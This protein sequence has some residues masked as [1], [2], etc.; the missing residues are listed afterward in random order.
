MLTVVP[1]GMFCIYKRIAKISGIF[2]MIFCFNLTLIGN[3]GLQ[4]IMLLAI[5]FVN[6]DDEFLD[7]LF[8]LGEEK[9]VHSKDGRIITL[10]N[11]EELSVIIGIDIFIIIIF[12]IFSLFVFF[13]LFRIN[14]GHFDLTPGGE[15]NPYR[16]L[17]IS[18][19]KTIMILFIIYIVIMSIIDYYN[20]HLKKEEDFK[21]VKNFSDLRNSCKMGIVLKILIFSV[22]GII[23]LCHSADTFY[24][25]LNIPMVTKK[26]GSFLYSSTHQLFNFLHDYTISSGYNI[27]KGLLE[28]E[29][30]K[31]DEKK[32]EKKN[33]NNIINEINKTN[34]TNNINDTKNINKTNETLSDNINLNNNKTKRKKNKT[35][36]KKKEKCYYWS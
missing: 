22:L 14:D 27:N 7:L 9:K 17:T 23:Y 36:L 33:I 31:K 26:K 25:G 12:V 34:H 10:P 24:S 18:H 21:Y 5:N 1:F 30:E 3:Y 29:K 2:I 6:F 32:D 19:L 8:R 35:K 13:P 28:E 16:F 4:N 20:E 11:K 15:K